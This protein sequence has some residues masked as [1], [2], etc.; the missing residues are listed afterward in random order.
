MTR[1]PTRFRWPSKA[2]VGAVAVVAVDAVVALSLLDRV[3]RQEGFSGEH[4]VSRAK[5]GMNMGGGSR[6]GW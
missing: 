4:V 6:I 5:N 2:C 3:K 1:M